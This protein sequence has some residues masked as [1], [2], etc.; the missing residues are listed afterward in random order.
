VTTIL[1]E[2]ILYDFAERLRERGVP[3]ITAAQPGL[4]YDS[5][6]QAATQLELTLPVEARIWWGWHNGVSSTAPTGSREIGPTRV[7]LP[8]EEALAE[9]VRIRH[10]IA[11]VFARTP[12]DTRPI[13]AIWSSKWLPLIQYEGL[14]VIDTDV[15]EGA[16]C[17]VRVYWFYEPEAPPDLA[18]LGELVLLWSEAIDRGAWRYDSSKGQWW[19]EHDVLD[20][21]PAAKRG[22]V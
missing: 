2:S 14:Y 12:T 22:L 18:S 15:P 8:I 1:D 11:D 4:D 20:S 13:E 7:W 5:I 3:A 19:V 6:E 21:W 16:P 17:P 9:C 10:M